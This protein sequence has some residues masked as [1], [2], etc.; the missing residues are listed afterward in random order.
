MRNFRRCGWEQSIVLSGVIL[1]ALSG[2]A[3]QASLVA[4]GENSV[5]PLT[6]TLQD[7]LARA[8]VNEPQYRAA[9]TDYGVARQ[10]TVQTRAGLLPNVSYTGQFLYNQGHGSSTGRFI[11]SNGVHGDNSEVNIRQSP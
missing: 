1:W 10:N 7:A 5:A 11:A 6:L 4:D 8:R 9:L 3:Q 2:W